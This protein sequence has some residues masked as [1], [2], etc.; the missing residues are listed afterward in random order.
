MQRQRRNE[1][2]IGGARDRRLDTRVDRGALLL[3]VLRPGGNEPPAHGDRLAVALGV[4]VDGAAAG[5]VVAPE[6]VGSELHQHPVGLASAAGN[7][8]A[9]RLHL[10][11]QGWSQAT[12][13]RSSAASAKR[14]TGPP[15][16]RSRVA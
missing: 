13:S 8:E 11:G 14:E 6:V 12:V 9:E 3:S 7:R 2:T 5:R 10:L 1:S 15:L 16:G 4:G